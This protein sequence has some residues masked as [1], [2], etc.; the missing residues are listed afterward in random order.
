MKISPFPKK[1]SE[2]RVSKKN[3]NRNALLQPIYQMPP[4]SLSKRFR[5]IFG[6]F[7][8]TEFSRPYSLADSKQDFRVEWNPVQK[9]D[10]SKSI[11]APM[12]IFSGIGK[13]STEIPLKSFGLYM[14][15]AYNTESHMFFHVMLVNHSVHRETP[16]TLIN[17]PTG[18]HCR[19]M[20][21]FS[22]KNRESPWSFKI[23][24]DEP[25]TTFSFYIIFFPH[26]VAPP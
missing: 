9:N 5:Y 17:S 1:F 25:D 12:E 18:R 20:F 11:D 13:G 21:L 4:S 15:T 6:G 8:D 3:G 14:I 16:P 10:A 22:T 7:E 26:G 19:T 2:S 23:T 24:T